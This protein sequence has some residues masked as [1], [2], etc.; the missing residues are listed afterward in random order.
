[1]KQMRYGKSMES[2]ES[3][4][5][6]IY[7]W[8]PTDSSAKISSGTDLPKKLQEIKQLKNKIES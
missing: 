8:F 7:Q 4:S 1:M 5:L 3:K 2:R 6:R